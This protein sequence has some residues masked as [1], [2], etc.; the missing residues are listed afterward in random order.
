MPEGSERHLLAVDVGG[1]KTDVGVF[2]AGEE[3]RLVREGRF[4]SADYAGLDQVL[5]EF[6]AGERVAAAAV[7]AAGPVLDGEIR[8][9]N[10][11]W[12]LAELALSDRLGGVPVRLLNDLAAAA[13]GVVEISGDRLHQ[14]K[15]GSSRDANRAVLAPGTGLGQALLIRSPSGWLPVATEGGHVG[16][17]PRN[18]EQ[19]ELLRF[20]QRR[21]PQ[22]SVEH[23]LSGP[24]LGA[25]FDFAC[26]GLG[27]APGGSVPAEASP[28]EKGRLAGEAALAGTCEASSRAV[29]LFTSILAARAADLTLSCMALGGISIAGGIVPKLL[30]AIDGARFCEAFIGAG[31]FAKLLADVPVQVVTEPRVA[32]LGAAHVAAEMVA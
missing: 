20:M 18:R 2:S 22:V 13:R 12:T 24:G 11:P 8:V 17:A 15:P 4:A 7:A 26:D 3:P 9:T 23:L 10:L 6:L 21:H 25:L 28:G 16:F 31:P 5:H 14:L 30:S 29:V 19:I 1:T 32:L 27:I